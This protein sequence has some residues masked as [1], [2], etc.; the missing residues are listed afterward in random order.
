MR[1]V[2]L[3]T[4]HLSSILPRKDKQNLNDNSVFI[5]FS[6]GEGYCRQ[7]YLDEVD[8]LVLGKKSDLQKK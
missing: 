4:E 5:Y 6:S 8:H 2:G 1:R 3:P 7:R